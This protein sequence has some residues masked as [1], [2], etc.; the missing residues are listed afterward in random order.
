MDSAKE[1]LSSV[2]QKASETVGQVQE[3]LS[4]SVSPLFVLAAYGDACMPVAWLPSFVSGSAAICGAQGKVR[5]PSEFAQSSAYIRR[6]FTC[7]N[8]SLMPSVAVTPSLVRAIL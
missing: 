2:Q 3:T 6:N 7:T 5:C 8:R 4:G 1:T